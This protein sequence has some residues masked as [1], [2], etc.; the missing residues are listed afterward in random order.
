VTTLL[1]PKAFVSE[2]GDRLTGAAGEAG[3]RA[4]VV[5][6]P[7]NGSAL[8]PQ[9]L[10]R[11]EVAYLDREVRFTPDRYS[12]FV[13]TVTAARNLKWVHFASAGIDQHPF[14][15]ALRAR[16]VRFTSS[17][18]TNAEPVAQTA[19][20]GL[21]MLAR[22][23]PKWLDGQRRHAWE[24]VRGKDAPR[25]LDQQTVVIVGLGNIGATLAR[26][27]KALKMH[28]VGV[29][30]SARKA[31]D[32]V[33]EMHTPAELPSILPR[34]DFLVLTC[35][36]TP[37]THQLV[38]EKTLALLPRGAKLI[39]VSRGAVADESALI[40]A[41][42][43]GHLAG[44][45][46]DVFENEPLPTDSALWDLP[47]VIV[48]PHNASAS[49]GNDARAGALFVENVVRFARGERMTNEQ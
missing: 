23:F 8:E 33:D 31:D 14:L 22:G 20:T 26:Y 19:L 49:A 11:I 16:G 5:Y 37:E 12:V 36:Y 9:D 34:C 30:R 47:N 32:P 18:G 41:L 38:N 21:L 2:F 42:R 17:I 29:R 46:L 3:V 44:A 7:E 24:P 35:P 27:C 43:S 4:D 13:E 48:S 40:R 15:P 28:V 6:L 10:T 39:N 45:H 1:L 25:D